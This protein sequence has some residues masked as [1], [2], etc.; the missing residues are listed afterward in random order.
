V[1]FEDPLWVFEGD[2]ELGLP[3]WTAYSAAFQRVLEEKHRNHVREFTH[4]PNGKVWFSYNLQE[5]W[6]MNLETQK[7][8][9]M[10]RYLAVS[11]PSAQVLND[12]LVAAEAH[13]RNRH[14]LTACY[15]RKDA[16]WQRRQAEEQRGTPY[17]QSKGK[18]SK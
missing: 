12:R 16:E 1:V 6:Q 5:M 15:A 9:V 14:T 4:Q 7:R 2:G 13:N 11:E 17:G 18:G 8:R 10:R 3:Q